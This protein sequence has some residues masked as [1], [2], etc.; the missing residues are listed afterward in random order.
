MGKRRELK[1]DDYRAFL[2]VLKNELKVEYET[3]NISSIENCKKAIK[4]IVEKYSIQRNQPALL[5]IIE[6]NAVLTHNNIEL[7]AEIYHLKNKKWW[8]IWKKQ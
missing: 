5:R 4:E 3:R 2:T 8:Q 7:K 6:K 1:R